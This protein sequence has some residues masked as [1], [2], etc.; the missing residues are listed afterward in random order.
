[1]AAVMNDSRSGGCGVIHEI[2]E[3]YGMYA[4]TAGKC[5]VVGAMMSSPESRPFRAH[6]VAA[7]VTHGS[8]LLRRG[9]SN[10]APAGADVAKSKTNPR[11][12]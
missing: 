12:L 9:L 11:N 2:C 6:S 3:M 5:G 10:L 4:K 7:I 8:A 1:M